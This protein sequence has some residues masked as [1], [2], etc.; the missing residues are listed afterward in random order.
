LTLRASSVSKA[1]A[2]RTAPVSCRGWRECAVQQRHTFVF[3]TFRSIC[4]KMFT[5]SCGLLCRRQCPA[6]CAAA[7]HGQRK[8]N[9]ESMHRGQRTTL[10]SA[11]IKSGFDSLLKIR[12]RGRTW[13]S[14]GL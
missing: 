8:R 5:V 14:P 2:F 6:A 11:R 1:F 12:S 3:G 7:R 10:S 13:E 9:G 4:G